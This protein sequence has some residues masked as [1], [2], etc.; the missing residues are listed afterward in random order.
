MA[1]TL[2]VTAQKGHANNVNA[3]KPAQ[4]NAQ[5]YDKVN[6]QKHAKMNAQKPTH[7]NRS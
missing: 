4:M 7:T 3:H 2:E 1:A 5:I 6:A